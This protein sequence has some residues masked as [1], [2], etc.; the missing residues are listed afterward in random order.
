M[1]ST[2]ML[3]SNGGWTGCV[4]SSGEFMTGEGD[5][6]KGMSAARLRSSSITMAD[7]RS[8][9]VCGDPD[10]CGSPLLMALFLS[11]S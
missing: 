2:S 10:S 11:R 9:A 4:T 1:V 5:G 8:P 3:L 6:G 7:V